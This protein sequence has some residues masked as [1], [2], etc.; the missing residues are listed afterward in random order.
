MK[1]LIHRNGP[2]NVSGNNIIQE[3]SNAPM[4]KSKVLILVEVSSRL[5]IWF[6]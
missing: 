6:K 3:K 2:I 1:G 5:Y 4:A